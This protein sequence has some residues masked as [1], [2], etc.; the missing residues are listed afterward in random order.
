MSWPRD[1]EFSTQSFAQRVQQQREQEEHQQMM[2]RHS[3]DVES[4]AKEEEEES[5]PPPSRSG[6]T[7][8]S[9]F[10][11]GSMNDRVSAVPPAV[12]L[13]GEEEIAEYEKQFY[14][15]QSL[16]QQQQQPQKE[17]EKK[18]TAA[19]AAAGGGG[20]GGLFGLAPL[21]D[22][23][24]EKLSLRSSRSSGSITSITSMMMLGRTTLVDKDATV[25]PPTPIEPPV[26]AAA[27]PQPSSTTGYPTRE[28]VLES[29][30][31]LQASGFF[32]AHAIKGTRHPLRTAAS[33]PMTTGS[34]PPPSPSTGA[35]GMSFADRLAAEQHHHMLRS[36]IS[37]SAIAEVDSPDHRRR[38][39][40]HPPPPP[41]FPNSANNDNSS[42]CSSPSRGLKR[43][44]NEIAAEQETATRK[45]VKK[46]RRTDSRASTTTTKTAT[47]PA[48]ISI[49]SPINNNNNSF[50]PAPSRPSMSSSI[51][52]VEPSLYGSPPA[53][54]TRPSLRSKMSFAKLTKVMPSSIS[55]SSAKEKKRAKSVFGFGLVGFGRKNKQPKEE[56]SRP[57]SSA[58]VDMDVVMSDAPG[59]AAPASMFHGRTRHNRAGSTASNFSAFSL[60]AFLSGGGGSGQRPT[61]PLTQIDYHYP[62]RMRPISRHQELKTNGNGNGNGNGIIMGNGMPVLPPPRTSSIVYGRPVVIDIDEERRNRRVGG[63]SGSNRDSGLGSVRSV[64]GNQGMMMGVVMG[65]GGGGGVVNGGNGRG[66]GEGQEN[67]PVW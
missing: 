63:G 9:R 19:T 53:S 34:Y 46:L 55:N 27:V 58:A 35:S 41:A 66:S 61:T 62:Q 14:Y 64:S 26:T 23:V 18:E 67:I 3:V 25:A 36:P 44:S 40:S 13:S 51:R 48:A 30:K 54:P 45:L 37:I 50:L 49:P 47:R 39:Q 16:P 59:P 8:Q 6:L 28:E 1:G 20:G 2:M 33:A 22:G 24:K 52:L 65:V 5:R 56:S 42:P 12:F 38:S 60:P 57:T 7:G 11:E 43:P 10:Q 21:W 15:P 32:S 29:Y 17:E 4:S 31:N